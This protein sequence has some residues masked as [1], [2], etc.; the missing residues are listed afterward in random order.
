[1]RS[2]TVVATGATSGIGQ[3]AVLALAR[4]GARIVL[5]ARDE[6]RS[7]ATLTRLNV[8]AAAGHEVHVADLSSMNDTRRVGERIAASSPRIDVLINNAGA[9]F[10][11]REVTREGFERTFALNHM[12][13]FVL[14]DALQAT[15][16][17]SAPARI[18][19]TS[20]R[21][22]V[23]AALDFADLQVANN[24]RGF[25]AYCRSKLCNVLFTRELARRLQGSGVTANCLHPGLV[26]TRIFESANVL[27]RAALWLARPVM[28]SP[29]RGADTIIHLAS[30][31]DVATITGGYFVKRRMTSPSIA[32][33]DDAVAAE[34][35]RRSE[36]YAGIPA[37]TVT[38]PA[39]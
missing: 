30:S 17:A 3:S 34:L 15:L 27:A 18:V 1:M 36:A 8:I 5:I 24:Y 4:L 11:R 9:Y 33:R 12:A 35:W 28:M 29:E 26:A 13:Y 16:V 37:T 39:N 10:P 6:T 32:A 14:T 20:S 7:A 23:D 25:Q 38:A 21:A 19:S 22:H 31:P 2:K